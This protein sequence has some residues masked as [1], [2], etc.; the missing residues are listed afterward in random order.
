MY[1]YGPPVINCAVFLGTGV[2]LPLRFIALTAQITKAN[3]E[4][5]IKSP[6]HVLANKGPVNA[7]YASEPN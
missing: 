2:I 5:S 1:L 7:M 6:C 3:P 4:N